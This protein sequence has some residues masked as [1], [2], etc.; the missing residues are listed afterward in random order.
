MTGE[1]GERSDSVGEC[2][3][4]VG[5]A[6]TEDVV[7]EVERVVG[8]GV[9]FGV[10]LAS[11]D[12][13]FR[14]VESLRGV[15]VDVD[16]RHFEVARFGDGVSVVLRGHDDA[17]G[18]EVAD[19]LV[20]AAVTELHLLGG[21]TER[22]RDDLLA[23]TD[24]RD[25]E[26]AGVVLD[27]RLC[28]LEV[29]GV[30]GAVRDEQQVGTDGVDVLGSGVVREDVDVR[31]AGGQ[32]VDDG[33]FRTAVDERDGGLGRLSGPGVEL[34]F[35][36]ADLRADVRDVGHVR[37]AVELFFGLLGGGVGSGGDADLHRA[38]LADVEDEVAGVE[39]VDGRDALALE[40]LGDVVGQFAGDDGRG[41]DAIRLES[42]LS[43][44]VVSDERVGEGEDLRLVGGV[45]EG[46]LVPRVGG[47][48]HELSLCRAG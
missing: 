29:L 9:G 13:E 21:A 40:P 2:D 17:V 3:F 28:G 10:V 4:L 31:A 39:V 20:D 24:A 38:A 35:V 22:V 16:L 44:A 8:T 15:V 36:D 45:R 27:E 34:G 48:E 30:T 19:R 12:V 43:D 37:T 41:V 33:S 6:E 47:R 32:G 11:D 5:V 7:E 18:A 23:E 42:F 25:G 46:L 1:G 26:V 14:A